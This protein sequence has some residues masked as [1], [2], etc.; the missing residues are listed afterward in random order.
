[1]S[2]PPAPW[3]E[4]ECLEYYGM[5]S[6]HR[7]FE[8][9]GAQLTPSDVAVLSFLLDEAHPPSHPL[10]PSLWGGEDAPAPLL[11]RWRRRRP[12]RRSGDAEEGRAR[13]R[14]GVELLLELE[15]RGLCDEGNFR[16]LLQLLRVVTRHDLLH[17]VTLKRPRT[18]SPERFTCGPAVVGSCLKAAAGAQP[19]Q[20][21]W[22][23][24]SSSGKRKRTSRGRTRPPLPRRPAPP[25]HQ[26]PPAK[27]T[28]DIRLRVRAEY[29]E[30]EQAL[31]RGVASRRPRG[32]G[33]QLDVFGQ[34]SGVLTARDLGSLLCG[35]TFSELSY[36]DAF[37]GDYLSGSLLEALKGVFLTEGLR[38][39]VG[40][41]DVRLLVSV[42][43]DDY[44]EGRRLL[45]LAAQRDRPPLP[46][47]GGRGAPRPSPPRP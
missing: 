28:C 26:D 6:L 19:R 40:R 21:H 29:C 12:R 42:D 32:P 9:V 14:D 3:E 45:L 11:E 15:R 39:A 27:V 47:R 16:H 22:E 34:A 5:V 41:E 2:R 44:E 1:M 25:P 8:V 23:T 46:R 18:V 17:C 38:R 33:R 37:W 24:G 4:E 43:Q 20:E 31:R 7:L 10:D 30:H 13:P 36:L 35:I